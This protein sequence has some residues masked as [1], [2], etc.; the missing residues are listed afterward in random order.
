MELN[1]KKFSTL[2]NLI[3]IFYGRH[4]VLTDSLEETTVHVRTKKQD[5]EIY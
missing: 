5:P 4:Y 1:N 3:C 2:H